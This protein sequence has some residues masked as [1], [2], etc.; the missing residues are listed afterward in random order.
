[1]T[2]TMNENPEPIDKA[3]P[4]AEPKPEPKPKKAKAEKSERAESKRLRPH[5]PHPLQT[6][7]VANQLHL[8]DLARV[9]GADCLA[10]EALDFLT[11]CRKPDSP[12]EPESQAQSRETEGSGAQ[13]LSSAV[14]SPSEAQAA[15][16]TPLA[17]M[18][19]SS[20]QRASA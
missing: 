2:E 14:A 13:S 18:T 20:S 17:S 1:M 5:R 11:S 19:P 10:P 4:P 3:P 7:M 16:I 12:P 6:L 9:Y 8:L 15:A